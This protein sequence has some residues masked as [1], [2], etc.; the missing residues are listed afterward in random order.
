LGW[1][2]SY[3]TTAS[4]LSADITGCTGV[5]KW[6]PVLQTYKSYIVGGPPSFDFTIT[7]GMGLF[8]DVT[9]ESVWYGEG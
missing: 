5:S 9:V 1:Y 7:R 6:D 2:H 4:S 8:I 3:N